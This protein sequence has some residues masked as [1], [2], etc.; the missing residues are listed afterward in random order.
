MQE[1]GRPFF[2]KNKEIM[3]LEYSWKYTHQVIG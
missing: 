2:W 1:T 3:L